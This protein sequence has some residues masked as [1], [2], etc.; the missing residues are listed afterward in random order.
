M[1]TRKI[2]SFPFS[3]IL[4]IT[5]AFG[6]LSQAHAEAALD[7]PADD[8]VQ[9]RYAIL[10]AITYGMSFTNDNKVFC[11][12]SGSAGAAIKYVVSGTLHKRYG[13]R[14]EQI[15]YWAERTT[16]DQ[17]FIFDEHAVGISS[18]TYLFTLYVD[19]YSKDKHERLVFYKEKTKR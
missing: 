16:N 12:A 6:T 5:L 8:P 15:C 13:D 7:A 4:I 18:G 1:K 9:A 10:D 11:C 17:T 14:M 2:L 19:I 3:I